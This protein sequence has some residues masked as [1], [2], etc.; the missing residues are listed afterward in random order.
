M[1]M[2]FEI[3]HHLWVDASC[4]IQNPGKNLSVEKTL[5]AD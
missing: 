5:L 1:A 2:I 3:K 4:Q